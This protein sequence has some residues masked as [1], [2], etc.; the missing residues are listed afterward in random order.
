MLANSRKCK[1]EIEI[2]GADLTEIYW[3]CHDFALDNRD[4]T[5]VQ[6]RVKRA[7]EIEDKIAKLIWR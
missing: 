5:S 3:I 4:K 7:K 2:D 6:D 1:Y